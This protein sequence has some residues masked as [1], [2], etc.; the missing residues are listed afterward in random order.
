MPEL[1]SEVNTVVIRPKPEVSSEFNPSRKPLALTPNFCSSHFGSKE[2]S[3]L[4]SRVRYSG[5]LPAKSAICVAS[6][7]MRMTKASTSTMRKVIED[8]HRRH[9]ARQAEPLQPVGDRIEEIGKHHA[10]ARKA[11]GWR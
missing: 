8:D 9:E 4:C 11:A 3:R 5:S 1:H 7:G 10:G 2:V 6:T